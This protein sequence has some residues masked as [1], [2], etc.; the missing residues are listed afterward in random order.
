[1]N[2][3]LLSQLYIKLHNTASR[4]RQ[5]IFKK[6]VKVILLRVQMNQYCIINGREAN[7]WDAYLTGWKMELVGREKT[8]ASRWVLF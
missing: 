1:M 3:C 7:S 5:T 4:S 6:E 2:H 8:N